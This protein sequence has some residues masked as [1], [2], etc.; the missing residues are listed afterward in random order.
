MV[1]TMIKLMAEVPQEMGWRAEEILCRLAGETSPA[2]LW[3]RI[4]SRVKR[5]EMNGRNGGTS[6]AKRRSGKTR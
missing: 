5:L 1:P 3:A 6:M 4:R 2:L